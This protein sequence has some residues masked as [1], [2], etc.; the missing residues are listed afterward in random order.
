L[1]HRSL[2]AAVSDL[3]TVLGADGKIV[4][5]TPAMQSLLGEA[6]G[7]EVGRDF[8]EY[9][10][11]DDRARVRDAF[12]RGLAAGA[13][14]P[15]PEHRIRR[16]DGSY[17]RVEPGG[18]DEAALQQA[19]RLQAVG[20]LAGG[21]AHD[22]NN[23]L[24]G[25]LGFCDLALMELPA[26]HPLLPLLKEIRKSADRAA[27]V[28]RQ[29]LVFSR[30]QVIA[31]SVLGVND[32]V[33]GMT[34]MLRRILG[35]DIQLELALASD[36]G[37]VRVDAGQLD[38]VVMNLAINARD[39]MPRGGRLSVST[40]SVDEPAEAA[41]IAARAAVFAGRLGGERG[42]EDE[43]AGAGPGAGPGGPDEPR[44]FVH[45][46][47]ADT[48]CGMTEDVKRHI[49]EPFFTTKPKGKGTGLGLA[50]IHGIVVQHGGLVEV[51]S[52]AG[53]GT[54]VHVYLPALGADARPAGARPRAEPVRGGTETV[55]VIED[56]DAVRDIT[57]RV[58]RR[59][60]Y[61]VLEARSGYEALGIAD[62]REGPI[63]LI[64]SDVILSDLRGPKVA[65]DVKARRP[66]AKV[67]FMSGY[68][69]EK[70]DAE[71]L[72][73]RPDAFV[74]KPFAADALARKVREILDRPAA[75]D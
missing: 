8:F 12:E 16:R 54:A 61:T 2:I 11:P 46:T 60:G 13:K 70:L 66:A 30:R 29:L 41:S 47:I 21:V 34:K 74:P 25:V 15:V 57:V 5:L 36:L 65:E 48:G 40:H 68:A 52:E 18:T 75:A 9:V 3:L 58:L 23:A 31:P 20:Q 71:G 56:E 49:F 19:E 14:V 10:H 45:L 67:L 33:E 64:L 32:A 35:E 38:Q 62:R 39:A 69:G 26:E 55:L 7:D 53:R 6:S 28:A 17:R 27:G 51:E 24:T 44:R 43:R 59:L 4:Y 22:F 42:P 73:I 37:A 1:R 72:E 50:M 63:D